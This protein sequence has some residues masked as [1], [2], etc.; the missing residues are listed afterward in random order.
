MSEDRR[1]AK[2]EPEIPVR[3]GKS[4]GGYAGCAHLKMS[5]VRDVSLLSSLSS[6]STSFRSCRYTVSAALCW[7]DIMLVAGLTCSVWR[8]VGQEKSACKKIETSGLLDS[9]P[10]GGRMRTPDPTALLRTAAALHRHIRIPLDP[11]YWA[12]L[13]SASVVCGNS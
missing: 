10:A 11:S 5:S 1:K 2:A 3:H 6:S 8:G 9:S 7:A 13:D 4:I 12:I